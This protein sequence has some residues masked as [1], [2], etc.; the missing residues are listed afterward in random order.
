M[1][2]SSKWEGRTGS[3]EFED[4][5]SHSL[6][7]PLKPPSKL[8]N[9]PKPQYCRTESTRGGR[10]VTLSSSHFKWARATIHS[11]VCQGLF[12]GSHTSKAQELTYIENAS[13]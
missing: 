10:G 7:S 13:P 9:K 12:S 1:Q 6:L 2:R 3:S 4:S 8:N 5:V 11:S